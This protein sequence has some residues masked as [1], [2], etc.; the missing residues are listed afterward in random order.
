MA[1][2]LEVLGSEFE[3]RKRRDGARSVPA[4]DD[5]PLPPDEV[6]VRVERVLADAVKHAVHAAVDPL[7]SP[8]TNCQMPGSAVFQLAVW[9]R[10][11]TARRRG[12]TPPPV[13]L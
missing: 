4:R 10:R 1:R 6:K 2:T 7:C 9:L 13:I 11:E 12:D 5:R 8:G 3:R